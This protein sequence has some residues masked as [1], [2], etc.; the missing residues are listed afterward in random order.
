MSARARL[1]RLLLALVLALGAS[2]ADAPAP[3]A[4][5]TA[6]AAEALRTKARAVFE[7]RE[8][9][10]LD[11]GIALEPLQRELAAIGA[12]LSAAGLDSLASGAHYRAAGVAT[13][14]DR[15]AEARHQLHLAI[16]AAVRCRDATRELA[17]RAYLADLVVTRDPV[18]TLE[19]VRTLVPRARR[20]AGRSVLADL[21]FTE[22]RAWLVLGRPRES[23][24]AARRAAGHYRRA[25]VPTQEAAAL[26]AASQ[27]LR[28]L[29]RP[30]EALALAD[31][32]LAMSRRVRLG[33]A[34]SRAMVERASVLRRIGRAPEALAVLDE[35]ERYNRQ[36]GDRGQ[37]A[38]VR[39]F[40][41]SV[42]LEAGHDAECLA[43]ADSIL[44]GGESDEMLELYARAY[45]AGAL[46][47]LGRVAEADTLLGTLIERRE[48]YIDAIADEALRASAHVHLG[49]LYL[50]RADALVRLGRP[51][52]AWQVTE[53]GSARA[54]KRALGVPVQP[55]V[56][57]V[58]AHLRRTHT[59]LVAI[60]SL[61][62]RVG[63]VFVLVGGRVHALP[64]R[65]HLSPDEV[66]GALDML[67]RPSGSIVGDPRITRVGQALLD[68][69][70]PLLGSD[71]ERLVL[72]PPDALREFPLESLPMP[73]PR[74]PR[75][76]ERFAISYTPA[77]AL[78]PA[79][80]ARAP[81]DAGALVVAA[82]VVQGQG[83]VLRAVDA[84]TRSRVTRP[85]P[86][87]REEARVLRAAGARVLEG[88]Q[89]TLERIRR[90]PHGALLHFATHAFEQPEIAPRG[91]LVLAG[92]PALLTAAAVESLGLAADLVSLSAC[93]T[94]GG[95]SYRNEGSYG[96]TRAFLAAGARTVV[97]T[98]WEVSDRAAARAMVLFHEGLARGLAR[99]AA[100]ATALQ[101]LAREGYPPRDRW[102][103]L[104]VGLGDTGSP[105]PG[106]RTA[107]SGK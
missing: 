36:R 31:S 105:L 20:L 100:L 5:P 76:G 9:A 67:R 56:G 63:R 68:G 10:R 24:T 53:R 92:E 80:A 75:L 71:I 48:R 52:E 41:L 91:A 103:F 28:F 62:R 47:G 93:Q 40:R 12:E 27:A 44:A 32:V 2:L 35:A 33:V 83:A 6:T 78:L 98:R 8:K 97:A 87:A 39:R 46:I 3:G 64:I 11:G 72:V 104:I 42:L 107:A 17:A 1:P 106:G 74:A 89:A 13:R 73:G 18:G 79:L 58:L 82:P 102:A 94:L 34:T 99:D 69:V 37:L 49:L 90:E 45:R 66:Q 65:R 43:Y 29:G 15:D 16:A 54:L 70:W 4:A 38:T 60:T 81:R 61:E 51:E 59:A 30:H 50:L 86:G 23:L 19:A 26:M 7:K 14:R 85:L 21:H 77:A 101:R 25:D 96:L 84:L 55:E 88:P 57:A 22:A 95:L